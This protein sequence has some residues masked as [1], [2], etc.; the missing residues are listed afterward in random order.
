MKIVLIGFMGAGKTTVGR[1][2][3]KKLPIEYVDMDDLLLEKSGQSSINDIFDKDGELVF[4]EL[5][6]AVAKELQHRQNIVLATGGG[7]V[8]NKIILDYLGHDGV[9]VFLKTSYEESDKRADKSTR[10]LFKDAAKAKELYNFRLPLYER[11]AEVIIETD[12]K[13]AEMVA[14]EIVSLLS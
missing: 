1:L 13:T 10:P 14:D 11:Y 9:I 6:I 2:L 8:M 5:E 12:R 4:R 3:A 7:V